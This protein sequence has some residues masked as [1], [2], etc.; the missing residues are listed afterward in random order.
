[1]GMVY[2]AVASPCLSAMASPSL[3]AQLRGWGSGFVS[4]TSTLE[5][6]GNADSQVLS[7]IC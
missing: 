6:V 7:Q 4:K 3:S 5:L 2:R 1:M